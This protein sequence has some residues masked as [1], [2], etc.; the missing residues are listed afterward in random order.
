MILTNNYQFWG[1]HV[2]L[3]PITNVTKHLHTLLII[4]C[5]FN[6]IHEKVQYLYKNGKKWYLY[7]LF[8]YYAFPTAYMVLVRNGDGSAS[9]RSGGS[10][11]QLSQKVYFNYC[12]QWLNFNFHQCHGFKFKNFKLKKIL[13][14]RC[15]PNGCM[16][17]FKILKEQPVYLKLA[18]ISFWSKSTEWWPF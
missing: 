12:L 15:K 3:S 9:N 14:P 4:T 2:F 13:L 11:R 7:I 1:D 17:R 16:K 5:K 8:L 18:L 10:G 6:P